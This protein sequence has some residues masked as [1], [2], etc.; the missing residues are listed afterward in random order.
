MGSK[1][2][3]TPMTGTPNVK[4]ALNTA[5]GELDSVI[6][7][8]GAAD[9]ALMGQ[10]E[11]GGTDGGDASAATFN[12]RPLEEFVD[13]DGLVAIASDRFT[14][15]AGTYLLVSEGITGL[16]TGNARLQLYNYTQSSVVFTGESIDED[17][18]SS[19]VLMCVFTADGSDAY[20]I[21]QYTENAQSGLGLGPD[22]GAG[23]GDEMYLDAMIVRFA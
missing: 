5:L 11:T 6:G 15:E 21:R 12:V 14:P 13:S 23:L 17:N 16:A 4:T 10:S 9:V 22:D 7:R 20:E 8:V 3:H 1:E 2:H 18:N 19:A